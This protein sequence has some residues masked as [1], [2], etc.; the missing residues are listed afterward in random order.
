[1][2]EHVATHPTA[3]H[4]LAP[5]LWL[6]AYQ[7]QLMQARVRGDAKPLMVSKNNNLSSLSNLEAVSK[8]LA[9]AASQSDA[10]GKRN[11]SAFDALLTLAPP[12]RS[13]SAF[14][15]LLQPGPHGI[16]PTLSPDLIALRARAERA[17]APVSVYEEM[18]HALF[19]QGALSPPPEAPVMPLGTPGF[20]SYYHLTDTEDPLNV[21]RA[22]GRGRATVAGSN[23]LAI[24]SDDDLAAARF[25]R[26]LSWK[27][28]LEAGRLVEGEG[29]PYWENPGTTNL[30]EFRQR[31]P[32]MTLHKDSDPIHVHLGEAP[33][34]VLPSGAHFRY[35]G[36]PM[37]NGLSEDL[38]RYVSTKLEALERGFLGAQSSDELAAAFPSLWAP[39]SA[40]RCFLPYFPH[41]DPPPLASIAEGIVVDGERWYHS[42]CYPLHLCSP[43][44]K[45]ALEKGLGINDGRGEMA[46]ANEAVTLGSYLTPH[47]CRPMTVYSVRTGAPLLLHPTSS[48]AL[49]KWCSTTQIHTHV[50]GTYEDYKSIDAP[51]VGDPIGIVLHSSDGTEMGY[52]YPA[53][54]SSRYEH[55]LRHALVG[56]YSLVR[57]KDGSLAAVALR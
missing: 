33:P 22:V 44:V 24:D 13:A 15:S 10:S 7:L 23:V 49:R 26:Q 45:A 14:A 28:R 19:Q 16:S 37:P 38:D 50:W 12:R 53:V 1:M 6:T 54:F 4:L 52:M 17:D 47:R 11:H 18:I 25:I 48:L 30:R 43:M 9:S 55:C 29:Q 32:E 34:L 35:D 5:P 39:L 31:G 27:K 40:A 20:A 3:S 51:L 36:A 41:E 46:D 57:S 8:A 21:I 42:S 2:Y 56:R